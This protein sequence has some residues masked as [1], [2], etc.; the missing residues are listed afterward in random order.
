VLDIRMPKPEKAKKEAITVTIDHVLV[1]RV[2]SHE[3]SS[4]HG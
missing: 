2:C 4:R 1:S 3:R